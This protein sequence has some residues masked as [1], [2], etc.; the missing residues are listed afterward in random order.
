MK[1]FANSAGLKFQNCNIKLGSLKLS[2]E[3]GNETSFVRKKKKKKKGK[4][5]KEDVSYRHNIHTIF[6]FQLKSKNSEFNVIRE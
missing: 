2:R 1:K 3:G 5:P 4:T 6:F